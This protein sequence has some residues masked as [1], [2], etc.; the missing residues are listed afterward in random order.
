MASHGPAWQ[1]DSVNTG[2]RWRRDETRRTQLKQEQRSASVMGHTGVNVGGYGVVIA[3]CEFEYFNS[4]SE[5]FS[6]T[7][8]DLPLSPASCR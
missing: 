5:L 8:V 6:F 1:R 2:A 4:E 3:R 7:M